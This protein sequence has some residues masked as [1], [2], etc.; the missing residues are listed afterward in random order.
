MVTITLRPSGDK[1]RDVRK[2]R[3]IHGTL[4]SCPGKDHFSLQ[5]YEAGRFFLLEFPN[6]STGLTA[7]LMTRLIELA[8]EENIRVELIHIQ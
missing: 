1:G 2:L 6:E 7:E 8:G 4:V 3:R 5:I